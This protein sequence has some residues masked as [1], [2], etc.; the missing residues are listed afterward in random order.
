MNNLILA[1]KVDQL[2]KAF[3]ELPQ[4]ECPVVHHF[5]PGIYMREVTIPAD[6]FSI[7]HYQKTDHLNIMVCGRVTMVNEDGSLLELKAPQTFRAGPGRKVGYIHEDMTW[8]NVYATNETDIDRLEE[9][10]LSKSE[11]WHEAQS[12]LKRITNE[13]DRLDYD[14][15]LIEIGFTKELVSYQSENEE[16]QIPFPSGS[17]KCRVDSSDIHGKGLFA[18][19]PIE[20]GEIIAPARLEGK[21]TPAGRFTNHSAKPNAKM[22]LCGKDIYLIATQMI[23]GSKGGNNGDEITIDYRQSY[24]ETLR[25]AQ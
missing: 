13:I 15:A 12:N 14:K 4:V 18:T 19:S 11:G 7:G 5:S 16:D 6:T 8:I 22:V 21:R 2:E 24:A 25:G 23:Q 10:F 20:S 1:N 17:Y 3:L 9:L